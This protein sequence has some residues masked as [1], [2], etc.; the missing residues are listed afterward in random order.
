MIGETG[1]FKQANWGKEFSLVCIQKSININVRLIKFYN[2][3]C[4]T[5]NFLKLFMWLI[6]NV[7]TLV[8]DDNISASKTVLLA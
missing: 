8:T 7:C 4:L 3:E 2:L 6:V 1:Y 5:A